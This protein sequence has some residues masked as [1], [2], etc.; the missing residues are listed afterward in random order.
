MNLNNPKLLS[1]VILICFFVFIRYFRKNDLSQTDYWQ[2]GSALTGFVLSLNL[3]YKSVTEKT[4]VDLLG[5]DVV[6]LFLGSGALI[7]TSLKGAELGEDLK[8]LSK[9][10]TSLIN[11]IAS[12]NS[13]KKPKNP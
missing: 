3:M 13:K 11:K 9:K 1:C 7:I 4:L 8:F 10:T 2:I 5:D 6:T 12:L